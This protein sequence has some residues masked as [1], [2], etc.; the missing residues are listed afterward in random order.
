MKNSMKILFSLYWGNNSSKKDRLRLLLIV[1]LIILNVYLATLFNSWKNDF[2]TAL[3]NYDYVRLIQAIILFCKLAALAIASTMC[4]FYLQ[5]SVALNWRK[6][7]SENIISRWVKSGSYYNDSFFSAG[8][9]NI[10]QRI[11][12]DINI[13]VKK[14][15]EFATGAFNAFL[16]FIVF[17][18]VLW[19]LSGVIT[20]NILGYSFMVHGYIGW[21]A[22]IYSICG[23][24]I[25][26]CIGSKLKILNYVQQKYEADFRYSLIR[27]REYAEEV[28]VYKGEA[29]ELK[30]IFG[31]LKKL[32]NNFKYIIHKELQVT[33]FQSGYFQ[34]SS[35]IP[36]LFGVPLYLNNTI[37][38]G[39]LMQ[40]ASAF[41]RVTGSL[42]YFVRL[43]NEFIEWRACLLRLYD[44][45]HYLQ[46][47][48]TYKQEYVQQYDRGAAVVKLKNFS[49]YTP[50]KR[51]LLECEEL[52][53]SAGCNTLLLGANGCGKSTLL[54]TIA[55][56]YPFYKGIVAV[57]SADLLGFIAQKP[58]FPLGTLLESIVYPQNKVVTADLME[59]V[60][61]YL[62]ALRIEY[63]TDKLDKEA[64]WKSI[65]SLG[66][67]QKLAVIRM[68][69]Q[70]PKWL[71]MDE[72]LSNLD[73]SSVDQ[74]FA[75]LGS[76]SITVIGIGHSAKLQD[77]HKRVLLIKDKKITTIKEG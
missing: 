14:S 64:D 10:D 9:D 62:K 56:V 38:L 25:T 37:K 18:D 53:L 49:L 76:L 40:G 41:S 32:L 1:L 74:V 19:K 13:F 51:K 34:F 21:G 67:Q 15:L 20:L 75:L 44:L 47:A 27:L 43:Y 61:E 36:I 57:P 50:E 39:G 31:R 70:K 52:Q 28:A 59:E 42:S 63:L 46:T 71:F 60:Q 54:K 33:A 48:D 69:L 45:L 68:C 26:H 24:Y 17:W 23:T 73:A 29:V 35:I 12:E 2:Y 16:T 5:Q 58:Y 55:G 8:I 66:E 65:L 11:N 77:Y 22:L 72:S 3:E 6:Y 4:A 7:M 30:I